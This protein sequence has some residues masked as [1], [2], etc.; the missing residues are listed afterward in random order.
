LYEVIAGGQGYEKLCSAQIV[1][2]PSPTAVSSV[3][4]AGKSIQQMPSPFSAPSI[5]PTYSGSQQTSAKVIASLVR[6]I[7]KVFPVYRCGRSGRMSFSEQKERR[8][9]KR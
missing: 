2:H 5:V 4:I 8:P 1:V 9:P 6:G 7:V 3:R